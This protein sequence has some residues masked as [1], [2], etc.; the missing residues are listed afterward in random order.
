MGIAD[1]GPKELMALVAGGDL[2]EIQVVQVLRN[3]HCTV[4]IARRIAANR[5]WTT[6]HLV[7]E[8]LASFRG[9]PVGT[10]LN[11]MPTLPWLSLLHVAQEPRT[12][13]VIRR[14]AERQILSR[15]QRM[16]LGERIALARLAHRELYRHLLELPDPEVLK[17]LLDNPR[18]IENDV[19]LLLLRAEQGSPLFAAALRHRRWGACYG[20]KHAI[21]R[22]PHAPSPLAISSLVH[23]KL[24]DLE[25]IAGGHAGAGPTV[26]NAAR[27][28]LDRQA[29]TET[30]P[31]CHAARKPE[32]PGGPV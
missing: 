24:A 23:L 1:L 20:V 11:I 4:E 31:V 3:P 18:T 7:R 10:V 17:A 12:P 13:P 16:A 28:L 26:R 6:S 15:L 9:M 21:A 14:H 5:G 19:V 8:R 27:A 29:R 32:P 25:E 2:D 30:A 22:A